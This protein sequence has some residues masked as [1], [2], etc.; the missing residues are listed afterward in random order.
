MKCQSAWMYLQPIFSSE[1]IEKQMPLERQKFQGV[2]KIWRMEM[3]YFKKEPQIWDSIDSELH[4]N[5]F[6]SASFILEE[7]QKSLSIYL[8]SKRKLF[9]RFYFLSDD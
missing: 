5:R 3:E 2:D 1:D 9:P 8:E 4:R 7:I 6:D